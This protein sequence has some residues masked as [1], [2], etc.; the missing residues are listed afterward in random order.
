MRKGASAVS[1]R[2]HSS[3][4]ITVLAVLAAV[5]SGLTVQP[6]GASGAGPPKLPGIP[7]SPLREVQLYPA[8]GHPGDPIYVSGAHF[9]PHTQLIFFLACP[10]WDDPGVGPYHN[11]VYQ[12]GPVTD[13]TGGFLG[14]KLDSLVISGPSFPHIC[15]FYVNYVE[16][17]FVADFTPTYNLVP[18]GQRLQTCQSYKKICVH[19]NEHTVTIKRR[20]YEQLQITNGWGGALITGTLRLMHPNKT[21][22]VPHVRLQWNGTATVNVPLPSGVSAKTPVSL[23]SFDV[24]VSL[25]KTV[26]KLHRSFRSTHRR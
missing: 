7:P 23:K 6:H 16:Q 18:P 14:F 20:P 11:D 13:A 12:V 10:R 8:Q 15:T 21:V 19:V 24:S 5:L 9:R 25:D 17:P 26:S 3:V 2:L 22:K 1:M 4:Y